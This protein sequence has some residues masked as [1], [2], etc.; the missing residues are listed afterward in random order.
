MNTTHSIRRF[1]VTL[2]GISSSIVAIGLTQPTVAQDQAPK[3][4]ER[5]GVYDSRAVAVAFAGSAAHEKELQRLM[6]EHKK[7]KDAGD[8]DKAAKLEAEGKAR[9]VKAHKQ[10]FS[11]APVDDILAHITNAIPEIQRTAGV[12]AIVSKWDETV[13]KKY[14]RAEKVDVTMGL[15]DA[16]K[17]N[18]RQ[19]KSAIEIQK[20]KPI[21]LYQAERIKD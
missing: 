20:H 6:T 21:S 4:Q 5:I 13:L 14:S 3:T 18:E 8:L 11:T 1:I 19:R 17:P 15:V 10:A 16:F 7:A 12:I 9:Q 2:S